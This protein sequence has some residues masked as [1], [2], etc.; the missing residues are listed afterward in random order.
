MTQ[1]INISRLPRPT[2]LSPITQCPT[3]HTI[4]P[5]L[6]SLH[7]TSIK[8]PKIHPISMIRQH[9]IRTPN[10][11]RSRQTPQNLHN[12][13]V[14]Q[15]TTTR[16]SQTTIKRNLIPSRTTITL[17][18]QLSSTP[19]A[20]RM[21]TRRTMTNPKNLFNTLHNLHNKKSVTLITPLFIR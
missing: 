4:H 13:T 17:C 3:S 10:N 20:H 6:S 7:T 9:N 16:R 8:S 11:I 14:C 5:P 1:R 19:R 15:V 21:A 2:R 12:S 18:K